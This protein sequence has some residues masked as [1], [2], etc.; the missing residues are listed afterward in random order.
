MKK[1][2]FSLIILL[3]IIL[4][5]LLSGTCFAIDNNTSN[6]KQNNLNISN[7]NTQNN[8]SQITPLEIE[9]NKY[10]IS[11]N[12]DDSND[13][14][15]NHPFKSIKTGIDKS[16]NNSIIYIDSGT[17][18]G[19]KNSN[20]TINKNLKIT[21]YNGEV[22][23]TGENNQIFKITK[24]TNVIINN[25]TFKNTKTNTNGG[26]IYSEGNLTINNSK[27][28]NNT[29]QNGGAIYSQGNLTID[30]TKFNNNSAQMEEQS[31]QTQN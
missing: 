18:T 19:N 12:G 7:I 1:Y 6:E 27:L 28:T 20:I 14:T 26:I 30:N 9:N 2:R 11:N 4:I 17:Y 15:I 21:S 13:G 10:Y 23:I 22:I 3:S 25:L 5:I 24:N 29:A 31:T 16:K 8:Y